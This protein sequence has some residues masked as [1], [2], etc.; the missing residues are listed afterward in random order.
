MKVYI[1]FLP[2]Y[3]LCSTFINPGLPIAIINNQQKTWHNREDRNKIIKQKT[4]NRIGE[5]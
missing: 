5:G 1:F 4:L 2:A 3:F